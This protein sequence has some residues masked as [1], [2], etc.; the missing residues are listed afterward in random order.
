MAYVISGTCTDVM[1]KS[2]MEVC[3]VHCIYEGARKL[4]I[5]PDECI[6]CGACEP[7]CP[8]EA[9]TYETEVPAAQEQHVADNRDFFW[10]VLPGRDTE[11]GLIGSARDYG[12][13][14]V[15]TPLVASQPLHPAN[16]Q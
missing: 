3:P 9:I 10:S 14:G 1:D 8:V 6:D 15:D 16:Q 7:N 11:L 4:Y 12:P 13:V 2:C 5:H